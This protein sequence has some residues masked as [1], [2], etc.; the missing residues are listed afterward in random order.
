VLE[1][2]EKH[3]KLLTC[4]AWM[5]CYLKIWW[6]FVEVTWSHCFGIMPTL[7]KL[8]IFDVAR[9]DQTLYACPLYGSIM[10][11]RL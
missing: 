5:V 3:P 8:W 7:M 11:K 9:V 10:G 4:V 6:S 2:V 1:E